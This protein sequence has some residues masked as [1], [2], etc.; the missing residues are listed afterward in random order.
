[1]RTKHEEKPSGL[2]TCVKKRR[3]GSAMCAVGGLS[4]VLNQ[5]GGKAGHGP[6]CLDPIWIENLLH[7]ACKMD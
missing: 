2:A 5:L 6:T 4:L 3:N 7:W 1:M